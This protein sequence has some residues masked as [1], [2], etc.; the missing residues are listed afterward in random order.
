MCVC[1]CALMPYYINE[2]II[3]YFVL[4]MSGNSRSKPIVCLTLSHLRSKL[5]VRLHISHV[6]VL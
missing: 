2:I 1:M 3:N 4:D 6:S 5:L